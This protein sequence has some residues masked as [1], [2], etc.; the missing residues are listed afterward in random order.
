MLEAEYPRMVEVYRKFR[1]LVAGEGEIL[2]VEI[3]T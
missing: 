2:Y 3:E 1:R